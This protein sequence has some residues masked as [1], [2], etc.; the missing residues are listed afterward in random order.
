M[1]TNTESTNL[2]DIRRGTLVASLLVLFAIVMFRTAWICDDAYI[3]LRTADNF[4]HG[5]GLRWNIAD[6]VQTY[7]HPLWLFLLSA[8]YFVTRES[9][10]STIFV[11]MAVSLGT[12]LLLGLR[13]AASRTGALVGIVILTLSMAFMDYSTSGLENPMTHLLLA[14]FFIVY[15]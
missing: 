6:R 14:L 2:L 5:Y 10:L 3:T 8:V 12:I 4:V 1:Q 9:F 13:I 11:S 7:T 15:F